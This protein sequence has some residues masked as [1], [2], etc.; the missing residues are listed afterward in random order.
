MQPFAKVF[1]GRDHHDLVGLIFP[2]Q[3]GKLLAH[4]VR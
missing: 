1:D 3:V 4:G 2:L